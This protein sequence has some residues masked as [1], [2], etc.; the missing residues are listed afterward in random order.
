[1]ET[2]TKTERKVESGKMPTLVT[3]KNISLYIRTPYNHSTPAMQTE[4]P[5]RNKLTCAMFICSAASSA[6][7][8]STTCTLA[9]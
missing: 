1:M 5:H 6:P 7:R 3:C 9:S 8:L 2:E 4:R